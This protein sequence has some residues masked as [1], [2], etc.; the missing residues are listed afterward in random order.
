MVAVILEWLMG[1]GADL[2]S[3]IA[4]WFPPLDLPVW[5]TDPLGELGGVFATVQGIGW[6]VPVT[7]ILSILTALGG[8]YVVAF[9]IRLVRMIVGHIPQIGGN[10]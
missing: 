4:S 7:P 3:L 8:F 2:G 6:W 10:G 1:V 9:G 5:V